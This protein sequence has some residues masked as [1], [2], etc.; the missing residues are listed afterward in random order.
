M[1]GT[2]R[3]FD[4]DDNYTDVRALRS[5]SRTRRQ[6]RQLRIVEVPVSEDELF[7]YGDTTIRSSVHANTVDRILGR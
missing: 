1:S 4:D 5:R 2:Y 6:A 3:Q 7:S